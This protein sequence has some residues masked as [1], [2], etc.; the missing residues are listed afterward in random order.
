MKLLEAF[1]T[2]SSFDREDTIYVVEPWTND[3]E[4]VVE[5]EPQQGGLPPA[6]QAIGAKYFLEVFIAEDLIRTSLIA[7]SDEDG[8]R[9]LIQYALNDA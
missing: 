4:A 8:C 6:A 5:R 3:S 7:F 1:R 2:L 9:R